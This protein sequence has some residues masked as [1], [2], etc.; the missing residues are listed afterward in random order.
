MINMKYIFIA[1][2]SMLHYSCGQSQE[3]CGH[4]EI[5]LD[6]SGKVND[7]LIKVINS[8]T[9][10]KISYSYSKQSGEVKSIYRY[11]SCG[12]ILHSKDFRFGDTITN[13][14]IATYNKCEIESYYHL[15]NDDTIA[16]AVRESSEENDTSITRIYPYKSDSLVFIGF[17]ILAKDSS[18]ISP[19]NVNDESIP[20]SL[21]YTVLDK[22]NQAVFEYSLTP[23]GLETRT[24]MFYDKK[25]RLIRSFHR[26]TDI[27]NS[28]PTSTTMVY[29][30]FNCK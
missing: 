18:Y 10:S 13:R 2:I 29:R 3:S 22:N 24:K 12:N 6:K 16:Y 9:G 5:S 7:T 4:F 11:D 30:Y 27:D 20:A 25:G 19:E 26:I 1:L 28:I 21:T 15:T 23:D 17:E 8:P 14:F